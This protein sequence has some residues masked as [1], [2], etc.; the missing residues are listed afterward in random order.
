MTSK[1]STL[2]QATPKPIFRQDIT[3]HKVLIERDLDAPQVVLV[4][5]ATRLKGDIWVKLGFDRAEASGAPPNHSISELA[6][7]RLN[8][9]AFRKHR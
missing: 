3:I 2:H 7:I 5:G 8:T 9:G 6:T 1:A 4:I